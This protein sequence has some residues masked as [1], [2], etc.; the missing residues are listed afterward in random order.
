[1]SE[2]PNEMEAPVTCAECGEWIELDD[3]NFFI[4]CGCRTGCKHGICDSCKDEIESE[5]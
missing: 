4:G 1:M 3:A 2:N 5:L